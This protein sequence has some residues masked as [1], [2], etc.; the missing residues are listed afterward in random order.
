MT[1]PSGP[2][3]A[4]LVGYSRT[5]VPILFG[6]RDRF[7]GRQFFHGQGVGSRGMVQAVMRAMGSDGQ[8]QMKLRSP[9]RGSP[10]A[11]RPNS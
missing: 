2:H 10:S 6:A 5:V 7:C 3:M 9:A 1:K 11:V 8:W 4:S